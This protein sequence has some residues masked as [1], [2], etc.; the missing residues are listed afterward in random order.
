VKRVIIRKK[1]G[2]KEEKKKERRI[3][4][5]IAQKK[6]CLIANLGTILVSSQQGLAKT[7]P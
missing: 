2:R 7:D 3:E 5:K 6:R 1:N 4:K